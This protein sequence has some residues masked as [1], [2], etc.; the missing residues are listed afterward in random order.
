MDTA[1]AI[2]TTAIASLLVGSGAGYFLAK[3]HLELKY[4]EIAKQ[5]IAEAKEFYKVLHKKGEFETPGEAVKALLPENDSDNEFTRTAKT[6]ALSALKTYSGEIDVETITRDRVKVETVNVFAEAEVK[7]GTPE[8]WARELRN[9]TEEAPYILNAEEFQEQ[10]S[11]YTQL[12]LT[13]YE[14]DDVL[15][16][17]REDVI[18]EPDEMVGVYNLKRFGEWSGDARTVYVRNDVRELEFEILRH[19]GKYGE[20]VAGFVGGDNA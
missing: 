4:E 8:E 12:T 13:Y 10:V 7:E 15:V 3:K 1:L 19:D 6:K 11:G 18:Q 20:V 5:E 14:G 16:D 2:G 17:E 9:R